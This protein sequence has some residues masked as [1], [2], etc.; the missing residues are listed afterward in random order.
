MKNTNM[1][2]KHSEM[3]NK[4]G[5]THNRT[6]TRLW[7]LPQNT[8]THLI[9]SK[10]LKLDQADVQTN[11]ALAYLAKEQT[12]GLRL[13]SMLEASFELVSAPRKSRS[14]G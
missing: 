3:L 9:I 13:R 12:D 6:D 4:Y 1:V 10:R 14:K 11:Y 5:L 7:S 8:T 2:N